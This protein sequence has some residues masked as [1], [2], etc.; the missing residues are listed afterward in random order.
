MA[1]AL[2]FGGRE[3]RRVPGGF[4]LL[5]IGAT[6]MLEEGLIFKAFWIDSNILT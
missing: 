3:L 2:C 5:P 4:Q 1:H 6:E